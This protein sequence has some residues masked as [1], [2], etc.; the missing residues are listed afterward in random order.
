MNHQVSHESEWLRQ[1]R[2]KEEGMRRE[3]VGA[4]TAAGLTT[5]IT[6][7]RSAPRAARAHVST[8]SGAMQRL[9]RAFTASLRRPA[10]A[11]PRS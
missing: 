3:I 1:L 2:Q 6:E 4:D 11:A 8:I 7:T 10:G 5:R 9:A